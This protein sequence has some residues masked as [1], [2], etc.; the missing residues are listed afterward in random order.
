MQ[1]RLSREVSRAA[2]RVQTGVADNEIT[3]VKLLECCL[4]LVFWRLADTNTSP[5][6]PNVENECHYRDLL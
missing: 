6:H 3:V 1:A 2:G 4:T 5:L